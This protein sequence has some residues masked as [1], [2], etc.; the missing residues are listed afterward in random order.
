MSGEK[1]KVFKVEDA[2]GAVHIKT[3]RG[4]FDPFETFCGELENFDN[5]M[6]RTSKSVTCVV[7]KTTYDILKNGI[8]L[9]RN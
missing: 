6:K 3:T 4:E 1:H 7:C 9:E 8:I 5:P 2:E